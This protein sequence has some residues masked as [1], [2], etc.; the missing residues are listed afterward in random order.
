M[1]KFNFMRSLFLIAMI[2]ILAGCGQTVRESLSPI[3]TQEQAKNKINKKIVLLPLAD[4]TQGRTPDDNLRRQVKIN[5]SLNHRLS[6]YGLYSPLQEDVMQ[7]LVDMGII[8]ELK[9]NELNYDKYRHLSKEIGFDWSSAMQE[10]ISR[11]YAISEATKATQGSMRFEQ[12]GLNQEAVKV[13]GTRFSSDY[14]LRGRIVEYEMRQGHSLNPFQRGFLPVFFGVTSNA[15]FGVAKTEQYDLWHDVAVGG[16]VGALIG[17]NL[18]TPFNPPKK[19]TTTTI[20]GT[21]PRFMT[22]KTVTDYDGGYEMYQGLNAGVWGAAGAAAAYLSNKGGKIEKAVVQVSLALQKADDG[23]I[24]WQNRVE[25][26]VEPYTMWANPTDRIVLDKAIEEAALSLIDDLAA[27]LKSMPE[28]VVQQ[29]VYMPPP[30]QAVV[31]EPILAP[32][33]PMSKPARKPMKQA[34]LK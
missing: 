16:T 9:T 22:E 3:N 2:S 18:E 33:E 28:S 19:E 7:Q 17:T 32:V 11:V 27:S 24:I 26:E 8:S 20:E 31:E 21:H 34:P 1:F 14:L 25:K 4:Y 23:T 15:L 29:A 6:M 12:V 30:P 5:T 13:I 10:E